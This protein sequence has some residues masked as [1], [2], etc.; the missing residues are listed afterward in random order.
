MRQTISCAPSR[1]LILVMDRSV[2]VIA[3]TMAGALVAATPTCIAVGTLS[4]S[5]G[6]TK[7]A[8]SD[9]GAPW[10]VGATP[11]FDGFLKTPTMTLSV[12]SVLD[13]VIL[14]M[15]VRSHETRV[16]I[17]A[18]DPFEPDAIAIVVLP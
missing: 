13:E 9:E 10:D 6:E 7:I 2:G 15:S 1:S 14:E 3:D 8:L 11:N 17:W 18:N 4:E 5:E 16:Q 12:C